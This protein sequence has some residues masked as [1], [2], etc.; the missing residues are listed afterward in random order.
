MDSLTALKYIIV[1]F[2]LNGVWYPKSTSPI[3]VYPYRLWTFINLFVFYMGFTVVEVFNV[4]LEISTAAIVDHLLVSITVFVTFFKAAA[5]VYNRK[6]IDQLFDLIRILDK[7]LEPR[8]IQKKFKWIWTFNIVFFWIA[9]P[10]YLCC[11]T[12]LYVQVFVSEPAERFYSSTHFHSNEFLTKPIV[13]K[14]VLI[15]E[16]ASN[17]TACF[18]DSAL[19]NYGIML[20]HVLCGH[21]DVLSEKLSELGS[22]KSEPENYHR[23]RELCMRYRTLIRLVCTHLQHSYANS[24][25]KCRVF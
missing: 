3:V 25:S 22:K 14:S 19:D 17:G 21:F 18:I 12:A 11:L 2:Q 6:R 10:T 1:I 24:F 20:M 5:V 4:F 9:L 7:Q 15:F 8:D 23:L 16:F 13:Y